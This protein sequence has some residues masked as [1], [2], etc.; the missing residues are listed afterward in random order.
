MFGRILRKV[1]EIVFD[2]NL[3]FCGF[4]RNK[5]DFFPILLPQFPPYRLTYI[6]RQNGVTEKKRRGKTSRHSL[7]K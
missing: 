3:N 1:L 5:E 2:K 7:S 4:T 6:N